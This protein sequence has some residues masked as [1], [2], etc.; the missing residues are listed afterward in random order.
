MKWP[1]LVIAVGGDEQGV[2]G[3]QSAT[4]I[5]Q[6][7]ERGVVGPVDVFER[8]DGRPQAVRE[9]FQE[10]GKHQVAPALR[11]EE[12]GKFWT[13]CRRHVQQRRKRARGRQAVARARKKP[14]C[15]AFRL[16]ELLQEDCLAYTGFTRQEEKPS[17]TGRGFGEKF[18]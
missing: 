1:H 11:L 16:E 4:E 2:G 14:R 7:V 9:L 10:A 18:P 8:Y 5:P 17:G 3:R 13:Q 15:I 6:Q 12:L